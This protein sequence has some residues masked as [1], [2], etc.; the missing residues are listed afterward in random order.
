MRF[1]KLAAA[2]LSAALLLAGFAAPAQA[3]LRRH[4]LLGI[5]LGPAGEAQ[6]AGLPVTAVNEGGAALAAGLRVGDRL[7]SLNGRP[8]N[9][10]AHLVRASAA[11][12]AGDEARF[13]V[14]RDGAEA[15]LTAPAVPRPPEF[16]TGG[17]VDPGEVAFD[18][19]AL[20]DMLVLPEG[21]TAQ[22]PV[23][24]LI[25]GHTC[26]TLDNGGGYGPYRAL[27]HGLLARGVGVYRVEKPGMGDSRSPNDCWNISYETETAGFQAA[28]DALTGVRGVSPERVFLL[29]HSMGGLQAPQLAAR[30]APA[31]VAVYG[32]VLRN[33][34]DYLQG[35]YAF[36]SWL[37]DPAVDPGEAYATSE[38]LR[39]E[40]MD[41]YFSGRDPR[42]TVR[43]RPEAAEALRNLG[44]DGEDQVDGHHWSYF[45]SIARVNLPAAWRDVQSPVL[46]V[47][48]TD[49]WIAYSEE[50][51]KLIA[52]LVN[53][54]RPGTARFVSLPGL[55]HG[56]ASVAAGANG[57]RA[58]D[59]AF[60]A[61]IADWI[62]EVR[63]A[64]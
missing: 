33:W 47:H 28:Y 50:D 13:V 14:M 8:I 19:G 35:I 39:A 63:A 23:V 4:A 31:G 6:Q 51:H 10:G 7:L 42:E 9:Q 56:M 27:I 52:R 15:V 18:G 49:D 64:R 55:N 48:G 30:R 58:Y 43:M 32:T 34:A 54:R 1:A 57:Q 38:T 60:T 17:T 53:T 44:W 21:A 40:Q 36:Q 2:G 37:A 24:F 59:P 25:Q 46:A 16:F 5:G 11:L 41:Y 26:S 45:Q 12:R 3:E 61:L 62:A 29:G 22:T 20:R